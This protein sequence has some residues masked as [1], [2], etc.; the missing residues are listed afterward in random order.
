MSGGKGGAARAGLKVYGRLP[1][2]VRQAFV[3]LVK[4]SFTVGTMAVVTR[5][6]DRVLLV[7]HSYMS[8]WSLPGGLLDRREQVDAGA[9]RETREEVGIEVA[10]V[11]EPAVVVDPAR[12]IVRVIYRARPAIGVS[13]DEAAPASVEIVRVGWFA[14]DELPTTS[15]ETADAYAALLRVEGVRS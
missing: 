11:G 9:V 10:L 13:P 7:Q 8:N 15:P 1:P 2:A 3:R 14:P 6:D 12:Q 4:P 5:D